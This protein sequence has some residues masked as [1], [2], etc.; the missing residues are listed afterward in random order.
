MKD[1]EVVPKNIPLNSIIDKVYCGVL[2]ESTSIFQL[3]NLG[4]PCITSQYNFGVEL[5][6]TNIDKI[7]DLYYATP[8]EL[9]DWY[10]MVS[11]TEFTIQEFDSPLIFPYIKELIQ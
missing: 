11:Y 8:K 6:N 1:V 3:I 7:E 4:I 2:G 10:K 9:L 5:K